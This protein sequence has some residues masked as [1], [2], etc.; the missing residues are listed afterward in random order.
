MSSSE[1]CQL[2]RLHHLSSYVLLYDEDVIENE[3]V[4]IDTMLKNRG[5]YYFS[6]N[7]V[8]VYVDS[9]LGSHQA[10][11]YVTVDRINENVDSANAATYKPE[12]H[13]TYYLNNIYIQT[14]YNPANPEYV[15]WWRVDTRHHPIAESK[16]SIY[17][18][19][20]GRGNAQYLGIGD[21]DVMRC[22]DEAKRRFSVDAD[23]V[24]LTGE[25]MGGHG[26]WAIVTRHP[27][28]FAAAAPV[29]GGWD[30][31]ITSINAPVNPPAPTELRDDDR[32]QRNY[33]AKRHEEPEE[34]LPR[35]RT[36]PIGETHVVN[37]H[38]VP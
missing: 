24:Y 7:Y 23:R 32:D 12:N 33:D 17:I 27:D 8:N 1:Q 6:R 5:Y 30:F 35:L 9:A 20:H 38:Q 3:R 21:R 31:R 14:E 19:P 11:L 10:D 28:V 34:I 36:S 2:Q 4:R 22:L 16:G 15:D 37:E 25:S 13:K 18:E 26:T 29:F